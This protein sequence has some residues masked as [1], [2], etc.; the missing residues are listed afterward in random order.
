MIPPALRCGQKKKSKPVDR[1][2]AR[3][4]TKQVKCA[5]AEARARDDGEDGVLP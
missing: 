2:N 3:M 4:S 5:A 1:E